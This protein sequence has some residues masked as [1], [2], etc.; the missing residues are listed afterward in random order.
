MRNILVSEGGRVDGV[1]AFEDNWRCWFLLYC[2]TVSIATN[3][4]SGTPSSSCTIYFRP[5][6]TAILVI[7]VVVAVVTVDM[8][9]APTAADD[10]DD[11]VNYVDEWRFGCWK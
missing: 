11:V 8:T 6:V 1:T 7:F 5:V 10:D 2:I 4:G 3:A 9:T